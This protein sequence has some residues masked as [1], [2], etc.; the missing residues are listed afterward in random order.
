LMTIIERINRT[1][2]LIGGTGGG[3]NVERP[4]FTL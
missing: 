2:R 3:T 1:P 4:G